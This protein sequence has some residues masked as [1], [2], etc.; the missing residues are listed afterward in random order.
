MPLLHLLAA[1]Q[2]LAVP[3]HLL[4]LVPQSLFALALQ[5]LLALAPQHPLHAHL[6]MFWPSLARK[7][8]LW[9]GFRRLGLA[10]IPG[11]AKAASDGWLWLSSGLSRGPS[12]VNAKL[13]IQVY[14]GMH[15]SYSAIIRSS[16]N[17]SRIQREQ[18]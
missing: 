12:T 8:R 16:R 6:V 2:H 15:A 7:P 3:R 9:P 18:L 17:V 13:Q 14:M 4:T 10:K 5:H 11:R 1:L